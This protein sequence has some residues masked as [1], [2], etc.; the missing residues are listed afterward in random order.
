MLIAFQLVIFVVA[1][2]MILDALN[3]NINLYVTPSEIKLNSVNANK[4]FKVGG[5]VKLGSVWNKKL[6]TF[7]T[8]T[9]DK[10]EFNVQYQGV[11]PGLFREGKGVIIEGYFL[12]ERFIA[13]NVLAKH[14]EN[15]RPLG[16][17]V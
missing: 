14:D 17:N 6:T 7:F 11:L 2:Y 5:L 3:Q 1:L 8:I 15:Y 9:D 16:S 12:E 10:S 13:T 4:V